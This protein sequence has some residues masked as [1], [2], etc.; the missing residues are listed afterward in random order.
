MSP[1]S[2]QR[3]YAFFSR[4]WVK[5]LDGPFLEWLDGPLGRE[6]LPRFH[7]D[8]AAAK[9]KDPEQRVATFDAD[10][11]HLTVV[12][13]APYESFFRREDGM[14]EAGA[15]NPVASWLTQY[16]LE[17][18]LAAARSL[19]PDHLGIELEVMAVLCAKEEE[20][21]EA[22]NGPAVGA[23]RRVQREFLEQH[24]LAWAPMYLFAAQRNA[25]TM[26]YREGADATLQFLFTDLEQGL[27]LP[28]GERGGERA[29]SA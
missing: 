13:L 4:L 22:D 10:F 28:A 21:V 12:N 26:L 7:A 24:L 14:V 16:G 6:L 15:V 18:D 23:V 25:R 3:L 19:A 1:G 17:V 11:V 9:V 5:E 29:D 20:A 8:P 27:P 2:R